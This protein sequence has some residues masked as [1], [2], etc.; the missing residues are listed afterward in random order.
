MGTFPPVN[1]VKG[2]SMMHPTMSPTIQDLQARI[3]YLEE[4]VR[5]YEEA[6]NYISDGIDN[7]SIWHVNQVRGVCAGVLP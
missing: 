7:H 1:Y 6:L 2:Y 4:D 5:I 3:K